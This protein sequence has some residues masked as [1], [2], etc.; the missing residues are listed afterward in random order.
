ML[1]QVNLLL[2]NPEPAPR[3]SQTYHYKFTGV[4]TD[5]NGVPLPPNTPPPPQFD[6]NKDP[7]Y[8]FEDEGGF[9]LADFLYCEEETPAKKNHYLLGIWAL[10]KAKHD[11][12]VPFNSYAQIY[13]AINSIELGDAPWQSFLMTFADDSN[14]LADT[15]WKTASYKVWYY[16][17]AQVISNMLDNPDFDGQFDYAAYVETQIYEDDNATKGCMPCPVILGSNKTTVSIAT[18]YVEYHLLYL[19]F[20]NIHNTV[21]CAHRNAVVPIGFLA[22]PKRD[23]KYDND[24]TFRKF[25]QELYH[26]SLLCILQPL[27]AGMKI[28][29]IQQCPD[30]HFHWVIYELAAFISDYPKQV[31]LAGVVQGWCPKCTGINKDLDGPSGPHTQSLIKQFINSAKGD[32]TVLWDL[33]RIDDNILPFTHNFP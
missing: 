15:P 9:C 25:K 14:N 7:W 17:P 30:G 28:P 19:L 21:R 31:A 32:G 16:D 8:P 3:Q 27:K 10:D 1:L 20:S 22:I 29:V 5:K 4:P 12:L 18:G 26:T 6:D 2:I 33:Y 23:W 24:T 13:N 11:N